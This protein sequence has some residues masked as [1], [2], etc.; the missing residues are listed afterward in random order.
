ML[1]IISK[2]MEREKYRYKENYLIEGTKVKEGLGGR[3]GDGK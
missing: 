2:P 3:K 1:Y